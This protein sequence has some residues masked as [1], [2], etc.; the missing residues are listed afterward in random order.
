VDE[1]EGDVVMVTCRDRVVGA[2]QVGD[3]A[4]SDQRSEEQQQ[5]CVRVLR[6]ARERSSGEWC[7][8]VAPGWCSGMALGGG[9]RGVAVRCCSGVRCGDS[10]ASAGG[11]RDSC[12]PIMGGGANG[13]RD[14]E[15]VACG[16]RRAR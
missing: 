11:Q 2:L 6:V 14:E 3:A 1:V 5:C 7:S 4:A 9:A 16:K 12:V 8:G 13:K 15:R 10:N